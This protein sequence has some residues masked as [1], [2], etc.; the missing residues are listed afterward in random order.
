[1]PRHSFL[2]LPAAALALLAAAVSP[3]PL[4]AHCD[5][6]D[7]PVVTDARAALASGDPA[8]VLKWVRAGDEAE[9]RAA[10]ARTLAV[11]EL[12]GE[13]AALADTWFFENLVRIHRAGEGAPYTGLAPAGSAEPGI[14]AADRALADGSVE[15]LI[16]QLAEH[17]R[18]GVAA[19]F[20]RVAAAKRHAGH[21]VEAG[22]AWVAAYVD[23]I[24]Y[25][26]G[27]HAAIERAPGDAHAHAAAGTPAG[28][29]PH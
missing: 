3:A 16:A 19:R 5:S 25:V 4:L 13:A 20:E 11:R 23:Y 6:L 8:A 24:H 27:I 18:G 1:M 15:A 9:I 7:G 17:A 2:L 10:F 21:G 26:E 12:G 28:E 29:H 14:A 22:R